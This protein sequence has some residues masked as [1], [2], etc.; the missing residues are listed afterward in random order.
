MFREALE[1]LSESALRRVPGLLT[2]EGS[3]AVGRPF[4]K[5]YAVRGERWVNVGRPKCL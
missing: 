1:R 4:E 3:S 5:R 2:K